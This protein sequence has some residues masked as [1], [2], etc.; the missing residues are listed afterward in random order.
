[1]SNTIIV[2]IDKPA[3]TETLHPHVAAD[4]AFQWVRDALREH[5]ERHEDLS[6]EYVAVEEPNSGRSEEVRDIT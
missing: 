4:M 2:T 1:M 3:G 5:A 6:P